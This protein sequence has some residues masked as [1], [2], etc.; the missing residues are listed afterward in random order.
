M[1]KP[2]ITPG[3]Y[4]LANGKYMPRV[5][6]SLTYGP[7]DTNRPLSW[8]QQFDTKEQANRYAILQ[9][10]K[11]IE[12]TKIFKYSS[13]LVEQEKPKELLSV[14]PPRDGVMQI[15][16]ITDENNNSKKIRLR[17]TGL[18][19]G[20]LNDDGVNTDEL[21]EQG[22]KGI[23]DDHL[24]LKEDNYFNYSRDTKKW[25]MAEEKF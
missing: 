11:Y 17:I 9:A 24:D 2:K 7:S 10:Q 6:L 1:N 16:I 5:N 25:E 22:I 3:S 4:K 14:T 12:K 21:F 20:I 15:F 13:Y 19:L 8:D 18:D 23:I